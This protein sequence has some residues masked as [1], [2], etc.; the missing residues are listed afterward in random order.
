MPT[1]PLRLFSILCT[2][3]AAV[4]PVL[5]DDDFQGFNDVNAEQ[6]IAWD[7]EVIFLNGFEEELTPEDVY[8][9]PLFADLSAVQSR[10]VYKLPIGG[11]RWDPPDQESP[12]TW[13]WVG[14][15]LHPDQP[16]SGLREEISVRYEMLYGQTPNADDIDA[17]L[18]VGMNGGSAHYEQFMQ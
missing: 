18:R 11:Y 17:I 13:A 14:S 2:G 1:P 3:L 7:P 12:L 4:S 15:L 6:I 10:R 8:S 16:V 5:A 9:N